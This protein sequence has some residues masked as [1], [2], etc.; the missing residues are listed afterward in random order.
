MNKETLQLMLEEEIKSL[1]DLINNDESQ[2]WSYETAVIA[3][4]EGRVSM[5]EKIIK[6]LEDYKI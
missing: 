6:I 2:I 1:K 4:Q 3:E 5:L